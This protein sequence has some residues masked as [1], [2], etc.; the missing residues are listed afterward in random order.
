MIPRD[1]LLVKIA[2]PSSDIH[3]LPCYFFSSKK[4]S[5]YGRKFSK[6]IR[7]GFLQTYSV[8]AGKSSVQSLTSMLKDKQIWYLP[9]FLC[10]L[11]GKLRADQHANSIDK[12]SPTSIWFLL[13]IL[14]DETRIQRAQ[15]PGKGLSEHTQISVK[16]QTNVP[17]RYIH[18]PLPVDSHHDLQVQIQGKTPRVDGIEQIRTLKIWVSPTCILSL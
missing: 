9:I 15:A 14:D 10:C 2:G 13:V 12:A 11:P 16:L 5:I 3:F 1:M 18:Y 4:A 7:W 17:A 6:N 8:V